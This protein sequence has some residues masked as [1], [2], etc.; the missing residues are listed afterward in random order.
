[1]GYPKVCARVTEPDAVNDSLGALHDDIEDL[2]Q[3]VDEILGEVAR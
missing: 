1:V 2:K 3:K